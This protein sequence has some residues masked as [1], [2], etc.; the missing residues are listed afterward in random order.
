MNGS[1]LDP[2]IKQLEHTGTTESIALARLIE[3]SN[4]SSKSLESINFRLGEVEKQT[5][6]TNGRVTLLEETV[7]EIEQKQGGDYEKLHS[8]FVSPIAELQKEVG[9]INSDL[10]FRKKLWI[11]GTSI[12]G[13]LFFVFGAAWWD[14]IWFFANYNEEYI[15]ELVITIV[16]TSG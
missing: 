15:R 10:E 8:P 5:T 13:T 4:N 14:K 6:K 2:L 9:V 11:S 16:K 1:L 12:L 7:G 3:F